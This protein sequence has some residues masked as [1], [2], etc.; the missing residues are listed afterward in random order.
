MIGEALL[1][2]QDSSNWVSAS[3]PQAAVTPGGQERINSGSIT[4]I[5]GMKLSWRK[6]LLKP[7]SPTSLSTAFLVASEPVPEDVGTAMNGSFRPSCLRTSR[8]SRKSLTDPLCGSMAEIALPAST[9][10]PPPMASTQSGVS[11]RWRETTSSTRQGDGSPLTASHSK[12][13]LASAKA[14]CRREKC[15][16]RRKEAEPVTSS[17]REPPRRISAGSCASLP[18]PK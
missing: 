7:F 16:E 9:V 2:T 3:R 17:T 10:L 8:P 11:R 1:D 13:I 6:E 4:A 12:E 5:S 15:P 14:A 18:A